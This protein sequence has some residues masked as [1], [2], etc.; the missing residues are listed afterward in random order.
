MLYQLIHLKDTNIFEIEEILGGDSAASN[1]SEIH[2]N[3]Y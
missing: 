2:V 3:M 1:L